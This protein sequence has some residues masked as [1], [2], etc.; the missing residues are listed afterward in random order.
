MKVMRSM[1]FIYYFTFFYKTKNNWRNP[2]YK[3][4]SSEETEKYLSRL[5]IIE[6]TK[7]HIFFIYE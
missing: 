3:V 6:G 4:T 2:N 1:Y 5:K 7:K